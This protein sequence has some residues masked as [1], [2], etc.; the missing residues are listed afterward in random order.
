MNM[1]LKSIKY[2]LYQG[3]LDIEKKLNN[4]NYFN[5]ET[6]LH[7]H[8][9]YYKDKC[10]MVLKKGEIFFRARNG[11]GEKHFS[12]LGG[13]WEGEEVYIPHMGSGISA[14]PPY[15]AEKGRLNRQGVSYFYC[16]TDS[17]TSVAEI[18]P[19]PGDIVSLAQFELQQDVKVYDLSDKQFINYYLTDKKLDDYKRLNT[20]SEMIHRVVPPASRQQYSITQLIADCVR[21]SGFDGIYFNSSVGKGYN[22]V[23][24]DPQVASY[25]D[26]G[27][28]V[29]RIDDVSYQYSG[30]RWANKFDPDYD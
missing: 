24:F 22:L 23:L 4:E 18:R 30:L 20:L 2:D 14:P 15:L 5:L 3:I 25:I 19:H 16:A 9:D 17:Y 21:N 13:G 12:L 27:N 7:S 29:I 8:V 6:E 28:N 1:P 11:Y 26:K 10:S